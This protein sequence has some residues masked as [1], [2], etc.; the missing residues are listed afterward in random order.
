MDGFFPVLE[1]LDEGLDRIEE[2][3]FSSP[4]PEYLEDIFRMKRRLVRLRKS[5]LAPA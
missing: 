4:K 2:Q 3:M 5:R 1:H